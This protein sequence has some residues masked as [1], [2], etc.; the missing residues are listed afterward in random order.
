MGWW[1]MMR[2]WGSAERLPLVPAHI[3][4]AAIEAAM[5][6]QMVATSGLMNCMVS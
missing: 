6:V 5:P 1:I 2:E 4:T 3:N